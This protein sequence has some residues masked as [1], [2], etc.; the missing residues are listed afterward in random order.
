[1]S[2]LTLADLIAN[3][4]M[5][6]EIAA[7]M[8]SIAAERRSFLVVA[9]PRL[10][11]KSTVSDAILHFAPPG[12]PIHRLSGDEQEMDRLAEHPDGGYLVVGEF[13]QAPVPTYIW[14]SPVRK[15][16]E[17]VRAGFSLTTALHAPTV[18]E[19]YAAVCHGN[20]V[21][22]ADASVLNYMVYIRRM[23]DDQDSFWRRIAEVHE[24]DRVVDGRPEGRLLFRWEESGDRFEQV[25][26]PRLLAVD[27]VGIA[28]RAARLGELVS[29][30]RTGEEHVRALATETPPTG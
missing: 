12:L 28:E 30:K 2:E 10:A 11:G 25:T 15:V 13:S 1:M 20:G 16:F 4:T 7:T 27:A 3:G 19:A 24:V 9:V 8:W 29:S 14:G 23:G 17:T 18:E 21:S 6:P 22:D 5:N 26:E